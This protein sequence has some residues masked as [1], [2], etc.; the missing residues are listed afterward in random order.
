MSVYLSV[1]VTNYNE[2]ENLKKGALDEIFN[3]LKSQD[4]SF[5]MVLVNDGSADSTLS[6]LNAFSRNH[7]E[8]SDQ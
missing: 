3:Y 4:Y 1:I 7:P 8:A 2:E 6:F 5:E